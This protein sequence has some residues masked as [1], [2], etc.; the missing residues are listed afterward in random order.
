MT[1]DGPNIQAAH[2]TGAAARTT[3]DYTLLNP[4]GKVSDSQRPTSCYLSNEDSSSRVVL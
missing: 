1:E 2:M 4:N 3:K